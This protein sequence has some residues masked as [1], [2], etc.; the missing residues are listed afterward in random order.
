MSQ[1]YRQSG[2][3]PGGGDVVGPGSSTDNAIVRFDGT[4]GK[5]IQDSNAILDDAGNM[6]FNDTD[7]GNLRTW[8]VN[9]NANTAGTGARYLASVGGTS[10]GDV[11]NEY[12]VGSSHAFAW[13]YDNSESLWKFTYDAS[14]S[15]DP[16]SGTEIIRVD[17]ATSQFSLPAAPLDVAS[18]G[19]GIAGGYTDGQLLIGK[20]DGTLAAA[21]LTQ[22]AGVTITNGD[23]TIEISASGSAAQFDADSGSATPSLGIV[24]LLG[25]TGVSTSASGNT[26]TFS[27]S[28]ATPLSFPCNSGT[29]TPAGNALNVLGGTACSTTGS[30]DTVTVNVDGSV[31]T[32][33]DA[34]SGSAVPSAG[35]LNIVGG[36][37]ATTSATG[38]TITVTAS[39]GMNWFEITAT[40]QSMAAN[41]GYIANNASTVTLSLPA[42]SAIGDLIEV[43]GKGAGGWSIV[44]GASQTIH[45]GTSSASGASAET[46][47]STEQYD[48]LKMVCITANTT[49]AVLYTGRHEV[50]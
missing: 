14:G 6:A 5:L 22:G 34:D 7:S 8:S 39:G 15:V 38:N 1:F 17:P 41:S 47:D 18:G 40:S 3:I 4:T 48:G 23:G 26:V 46:I 32:Q 24:E 35:V 27:A 29:A 33:Y 16:S 20:T 30:G 12:S 37:L 2:A 25:G 43:Q 42:S 28:A 50:G 19:T 45:H 10:A 44:P 9:N 49:W 11:Y 31:A 21:T 36:G 13:G